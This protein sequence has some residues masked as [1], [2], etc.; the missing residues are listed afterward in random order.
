M[1]RDRTF[2]DLQQSLRALVGSDPQLL[3]EVYHQF[4]KLPV[5][6]GD[7][8]LRMQINHMIVDGGY[9]HFQQAG[10]VEGAVHQRQQA[11]MQDIRTV[12]N[13]ILLETLLNEVVVLIAIEQ[14]VVL[15]YPADL[16]PRLL[17]HNYHLPFVFDIFGQEGACYILFDLRVALLFVVHA[18]Y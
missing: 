9:V 6:S 11:L 2:D 12:V 16:H 8:C 15:A 17:Q 10:S 7:A 18:Y 1:Q 13:R 3:H 14:D 4:C 5:G